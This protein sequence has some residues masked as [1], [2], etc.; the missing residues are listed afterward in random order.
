MPTCRCCRAFYFTASAWPLILTVN[1]SASLDTVPES[2]R[3]Q[4]PVDPPERY[5]V[6][7]LAADDFL[8]CIQGCGIG[9]PPSRTEELVLD[10]GVTIVGLTAKGAPPCRRWFCPGDL[11]SLFKRGVNIRDGAALPP[12]PGHC[13]LPVLL[14]GTTCGNHRATTPGT[15]GIFRPGFRSSDE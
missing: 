1:D 12:V 15:L 6:G 14:P 2:R 3:C 10:Y 5:R 11:N 7:H 4:L 13:G 9:E 8:G